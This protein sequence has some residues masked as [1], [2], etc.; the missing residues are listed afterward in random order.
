MSEIIIPSFGESINSATISQW[1]CPSG[2]LVTQGTPLVT[3]ET[4]KVSADIEADHDG[5]LTI[6]TPEGA[7]APIGTVIGTIADNINASNSNQQIKETTIIPSP[8]LQSPS[9][10]HQPRF[11]RTPMSPLRRTIATKLVNEQHQAALLTTFNECDMSAIIALRHQYKEQYGEQSK[12]KL[13]FMSFF[14][15]AVVHALQNTPSVNARIDGDSIITNHYY[16]IS[17]A[18]GTEKG[19]VVPV[20]RNCDQKNHLQLEQSLAELATKARNNALT[21]TDLQGGVFTISNGGIY[22]SMLST[23]I[24][25]PPQ[26]AILGMHA[27]I[28]RPIVKEGA[29]V[30]RPMMYLALTYDHRLIDGQQAVTFLLHIKEFL[31]NPILPI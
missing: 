25:N 4:D 12:V 19:L 24:P 29:I 7:D 13:G 20:L 17:I 11:T 3:L 9:S 21:L 1:L 23:P 28:D 10:S 31:E 26:S 14:I 6:I 15:K 30:I 22:G 16:D 2:S 27:I 5:I 8:T 18:I